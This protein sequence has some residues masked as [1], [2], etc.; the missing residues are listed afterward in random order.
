MDMEKVIRLKSRFVSAKPG[1][2]S[3]GH[4]VGAVETRRTE[5]LPTPKDLRVQQ[6]DIAHTHGRAKERERER[7]G[8]NVACLWELISYCSQMAGGLPLQSVLDVCQPCASSVTS[9]SLWNQPSACGVWVVSKHLHNK[10]STSFQPFS[11][12]CAPI[13][14]IQNRCDNQ[15]AQHMCTCDPSRWSQNLRA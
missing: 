12:T 5:R 4:T 3:A 14:S 8:R 10:E 11:C 7:E 15:P 1:E 13:P 2:G 9:I 6:W